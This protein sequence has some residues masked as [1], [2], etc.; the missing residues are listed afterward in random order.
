[1]VPANPLN[2]TVYVPE[3]FREEPQEGHVIQI[4]APVQWKGD[5]VPSELNLGDRVL[6]RPHS[7]QQLRMDGEDY[8]LL[9]ESEILA[10]LEETP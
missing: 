6:L 2:G 5:P 9:Q 10:V 1:M 7:G 3:A 4:G 8:R